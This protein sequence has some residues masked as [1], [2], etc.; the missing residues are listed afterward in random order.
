[1]SLNVPG[2]EKLSHRIRM[3]NAVENKCLLIISKG[4]SKIYK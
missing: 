1:M 4:G 2:S 3:A